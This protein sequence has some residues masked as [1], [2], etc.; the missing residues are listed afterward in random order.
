MR[1]FADIIGGLIILWTP[2][3]LFLLGWAV[4]RLFGAI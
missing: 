3:A 4:L 1:D 2:A